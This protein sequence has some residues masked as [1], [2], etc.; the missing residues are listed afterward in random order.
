LPPLQVQHITKESLNKM[1]YMMRPQT[2]DL[3]GSVVN[4]YKDPKERVIIDKS[5]IDKQIDI[6]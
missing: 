3:E 5:T 2:D 1:P 6:R 4:T